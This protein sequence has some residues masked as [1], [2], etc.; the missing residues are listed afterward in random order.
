MVKVEKAEKVA[1]RAMVK[2]HSSGMHTRRTDDPA[3]I[4][5]Q[6]WKNY[7]TPIIG[8]FT[9]TMLLGGLALA[10]FS[11]ENVISPERFQTLSVLLEKFMSQDQ[12][13]DFGSHLFGRAGE[14][15]GSAVQL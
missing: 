10:G 12:L 11:V 3:K 8:A 13:A 9:V 1:E 4:T 15:M 14:A 5:T 6:G 7:L 2:V